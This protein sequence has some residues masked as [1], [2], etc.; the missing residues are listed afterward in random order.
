MANPFANIAKRAVDFLG[1]KSKSIADHLSGLW[2]ASEK[3]QVT[4]ETVLSIT[5]MWR[6]VYILKDI[7]ST[8]PLNLYQR[9][10]DG[11]IVLAKDHPL[12]KLISLNPHPLFTP[13][14]WMGSMVVNKMIAGNGISRIRRNGSA[15]ATSLE[16]IPFDKI[17]DI[18]VVYDEKPH[19]IYKL[20]NGVSLH[21]DDVVH[22]QGL[23]INGLAG[24]NP[25]QIHNKTLSTEAAMRDFINSFMDNGAFLSGVIEVPVQLQDNTYKR[26]KTSWQ[27]AYG[28]AKKAGGTAILEGGAKY[29]RIQA[30]VPEAGYEIVKST[31]IADISRI[32]GVPE[33]M[34][35]I[36]NKPGYTS[37]EHMALD[38]K[39]YTIDGWCTM[40]TQELTRKLVSANQ[41]GE[42][43]FDF[44][45]TGLTTGDL[46]TMGEYYTKLFRIGVLNRDE[47]RSF[48]KKNKVE[49]GDEY[50]VEGNNMVR[51]K[52]IDKLVEMKQ[53]KGK[54]GKVQTDVQTIKE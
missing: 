37:I 34:L 6:A 25:T 40:I 1:D 21:S 11:D 47:V 4:E 49:N 16:P 28:G 22:F 27:D 48:I 31:S 7:L 14:A 12:N 15:I 32:T 30:T 45:K 8:M 23:S 52:D 54:T 19:L 5:P 36:K 18:I 46:Q 17:H 44:D 35:D 38:F 9:T 24:L 29:N 39:K 10:A 53:N 13:Y 50:F 20:S 41:A 33:Y 2:M 26:M 3:K 51:V 43:F 42:Y